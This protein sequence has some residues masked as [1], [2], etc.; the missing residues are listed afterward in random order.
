MSGER[1]RRGLAEIGRVMGEKGVE[2]V[3][4]LAEDAPDLARY[5]VEASG[6]L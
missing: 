2:G 3:V 4:W 6:E 1:Y 5:A